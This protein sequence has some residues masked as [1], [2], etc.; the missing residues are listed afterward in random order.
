MVVLLGYL[1]MNPW[2]CLKTPP[3]PEA[4]ARDVFRLLA[5]RPG[6]HRGT[7]VLRQSR[8]RQMRFAAAS[9]NIPRIRLE[10]VGFQCVLDRIVFEA[11]A[12]L[13][14]VKAP[15]ITHRS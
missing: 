13:N 11:F 2:H 5:L 3:Q 12:V 6:N 1:G 14:D 9:G 15:P 10:L 7:L 8:S 4:E